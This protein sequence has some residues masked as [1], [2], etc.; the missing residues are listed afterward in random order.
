VFD[1]GAF[2]EPSTKQAAAL[3]SDWSAAGSSALVLLGAEE[4][5]AGL[6]FRN[7]ARVSAMEVE[8]AGVADVIGAASLLVSKVALEALTARASG[9]VPEIG[10]AGG[11]KP[12]PKDELLTKERREALAQPA[13][14][15]PADEPEE[16]S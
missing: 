10:E 3:L 12:D 1:A 15:E 4:A 5:A 13:V 14:E 16:E 2:S 9:G 6:S 7:I 8:G 11:R